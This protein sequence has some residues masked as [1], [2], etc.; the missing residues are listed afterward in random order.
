MCH[1]SDFKSKRYHVTNTGGIQAMALGC[2]GF[3]LFQVAIDT[4]MHQTR[5]S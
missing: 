5:H 4:Y 1:R 3:A 2:G